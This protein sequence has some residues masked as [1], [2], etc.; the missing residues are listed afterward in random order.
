MFSKFIQSFIAVTAFVAAFVASTAHAQITAPP[1]AARA[2][3]VVDLLSDQTIVALNP[4]QRVD[5]ASL[6]K[7][8]TAYLVFNALKDKKLTLT[9][10]VK[11]SDFAHKAEGS[12]MFADPKVPVTV[13]ELIRGMIVQSGNDASRALAEAVAGT[14]ATFVERMN[15]EAKKLGLNNTRFTNSTGL[16]D[17]NHYSTATDLANLATRLIRDHPDFYPIYS[18][19]EYTYNRISQPNRNRLLFIDPTVDGVKTGHTEAAGYCLVASAK[20]G[21]RRLL[22]VVLGTSSDALRASESLKLLNFG[23][24]V[25]DTRKVYSKDQVASELEVFKG[26]L[27][28]VKLGFG[29]DTYLTLTPDQFAQVK[30]TMEY[31]TPLIAPLAKGQPVGTAKISINNQVPVAGVLSRGWDSLRLL[32]NK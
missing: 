8:M 1:I 14:E 9:Q 6:T 17:A 5:P 24:Q 12:R 25:F 16:P 4:E 19:K 13:D 26:K 29:K 15:I 32:W 3:I 2:Y 20:R 7:L 11:L 30:A 21:E 31:K 10:A 23:F 18:Q 22:S 27:D 28:K